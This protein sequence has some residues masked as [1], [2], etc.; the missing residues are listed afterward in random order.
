[1]PILINP[2]TGEIGVS[3][4][5]TGA[6]QQGWRIASDDEADEAARRLD[7]GTF[8]Q[9]AQAQV[10]R[11]VRGG[12]L[13][14]IEG[15]GLPEDIT[16]RA[17]VS[18]ELS[19]VTS[20][21]ASIAPDV[22]VAAATGG[23]GG[24]ASGAGRLAARTALAEGAGLVRAGLAAGRAGGAAALVGESLGTAAVGAGQAAYA[25]G[26]E[27]GDDPGRDAENALIWGGLNFGLG[28]AMGQ[29]GRRAGG[30]LVDESLDDIAA[31]A[32]ARSAGKAEADIASSLPEQST[33]GSPLAM[34]D[35][36]CLWFG[37]L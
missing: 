35:R 33:Q 5:P 25:E 18:E 1:M 13:G 8:E 34:S 21:L 6:L 22:A 27:L 4:D 31:A 19:P 23:I 28:A 3:D 9:Q 16:A 7:F 17:E 15:I 26:R 11:V 30:E 2:T 36:R 32:E 10:E 24:L 20:A 14:A 37:A 29:L 12:T